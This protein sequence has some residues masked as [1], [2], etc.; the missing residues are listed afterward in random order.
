MSSHVSELL[1]VVDA[2]WLAAHL[3]EED[4]VVGDVRGP[5]A[6]SRGHIRG[7]RPLV[8]GSPPPSADETS[9]HEL[10]G[11]IVLRLRRPGITGRRRLGLGRPGAGA[12]PM[13]A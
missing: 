11:E 8:L 4:L 3:G 9:L 1:A 5:N 6:H 12:W 13:A 2:E 10:A 7:S